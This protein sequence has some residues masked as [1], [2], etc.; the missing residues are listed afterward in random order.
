MPIQLTLERQTLRFDVDTI[1]IGRAP[2]NQIALPNDARLKDVHAVLR[3]VNGRWIIECRDGAQVR[4]GSGR[5]VQFGWLSA[6]DVIH[7]TESGPELVFEPATG[8]I[9]ATAS[10]IPVVANIQKEAMPA[11]PST[12]PTVMYHPFIPADESSRATP[13][14]V[15]QPPRVEK[16]AREEKPASVK[17]NPPRPQPW[18]LSP[19]LLAGTL[20]PLA[21]L[22]GAWSLWPRSPQQN[23]RNDDPKPPARVVPEPK[24]ERVVTPSVDPGKFLVL[25]G[26][27]D[28]TSDNRPIVLGA[29][30]L[31]N[32]RTAVVPRAMGEELSSMVIESKRV[33]QPRQACVLQGTPYAVAEIQM[34]TQCAEISILRLKEAVFLPKA[35]REQWRRV[36]AKDLQR[37]QGQGEKFRHQSFGPLP[38]PAA[39]HDAIQKAIA[40]NSV[41]NAKRLAGF[42]WHEYAPEISQFTDRPAE[43]VRLVFEQRRLF[44]KADSETPLELGGLL[45]DVHQNI[46]GMSLSDSSIVWT[47]DLQRALDTP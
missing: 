11:S 38:R 23:A 46:V 17:P 45:L 22:I 5:P 44:L 35:A 27:G 10:A 32:E 25:I 40:D 6:G 12:S 34:P 18:S 21:L 28:L 39:V 26:I 20:L 31:W 19:K 33:G 16:T 24:P 36:T 4:I 30:W 3:S 41:P 14:P 42:S 9:S 43:P 1:G 29:G 2:E 7:L 47:D 8:A 13:Q 15:P 37:E